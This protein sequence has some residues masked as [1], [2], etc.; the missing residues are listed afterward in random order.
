MNAQDKI[1][2]YSLNIFRVPLYQLSF[3]GY[4]VYLYLHNKVCI[5]L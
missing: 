5:K 4:I 1:R 3:L 2:T